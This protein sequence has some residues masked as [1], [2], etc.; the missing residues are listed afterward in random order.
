MATTPANLGGA[1]LAF[2]NAGGIRG[3]F[4][5]NQQSGGE[6]PGQVTYGEAFT[7]Q[8][9]ANTL[10]TKTMTGA[11]IRAVLEQ[12]F[13]GCQGQTLSTR[14]LQISNG[15]TYQQNPERHRPVPGASARS[16]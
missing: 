13:H 3:D 8:P 5:F 15:F 7:V 10:V 6:A 1:Q 16:G 14:V 11:Q 12:Q 9:F 4:T 2:M